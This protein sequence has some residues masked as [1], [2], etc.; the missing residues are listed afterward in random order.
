VFLFECL[1]SLIAQTM[2]AWEAIVVDDCSPAR[3][4]DRIV[5]SYKDPRIR[6]IRHQT[7][8]GLAASRNTG[9]RAGHAPFALCIDA[10]DFLH[11]EFLSATLD[12]M[13]RRRADCAYAEFQL[14]GLSN[15]VWTWEPKSA[16]ELA[17]VQWIPGPGVVMQ[18]SVWERV[19][20]YSEELRW[21]EDWD[22]WIGAMAV[23]CS[24]ERIPHPLYFYRRHAHTMTGPLSSKTEW[25]TREVILKKRAGFFAVGDRARI[26]RTGGLVASAYAYRVLGHRRKSLELTARAISIDPKLIFSQSKAAIRRKLGLARQIERKIKSK[27]RQILQGQLLNSKTFD[28]N[29]PETKPSIDWDSLAPALHN[30]YGYLSHDYP[31][32]GNVIDKTSARFVLEVGCGSGRLVPVYLLHNVRTIWLQDVSGRAL[33]L[34]RQRFLCQRQIRYFRGN[35]QSIPRSTTVDLIVTNRVFQHILDDADFGETLAYLAAM[36][37]YFYI[38]EAGIEDAIKLHNPYIKGRDYAHIFQDLGWRVAEQGKVTDELD[39]LQSWTLFAKEGNEIHT[40][41]MD[42]STST[43]NVQHSK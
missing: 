18:R 43:L 35:V 2:P 17:S 7:N 5:S 1:N 34:C 12:A 29:S 11:P 14:V 27:I 28:R 20:G 21:N 38:N 41:S 25:M 22:F 33:D 23:G 24:F 9:L 4:A 40:W 8:L 31:V 16:D 13:E 36:T 3:M 6:S 19:G 42:Q 15:D 32:L 37:R 39:R 10:D 30:R 26:F